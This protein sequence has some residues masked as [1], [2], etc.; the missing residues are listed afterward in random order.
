M[1]NHTPE[2]IIAK[3]QIM[4]EKAELLKSS[5]DRAPQ[6]STYINYLEEDL[7]ALAM[8][9]AMDGREDLT[10]ITKVKKWLSRN[11]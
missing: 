6:D 8:E 2:E 10:D 1:F 3:L 5:K 9:I 11:I 4:I 7:R